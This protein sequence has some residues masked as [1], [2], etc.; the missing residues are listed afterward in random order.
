MSNN[1]DKQPKRARVTRSFRTIR[2]SSDV[3]RKGMKL[4]LSLEPQQQQLAI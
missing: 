3:S 1:T 4:V 2:G